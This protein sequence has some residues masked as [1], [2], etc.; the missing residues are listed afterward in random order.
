MLPM[1]LTCLQTEPNPPKGPEPVT[2]IWERMTSCRCAFKQVRPSTQGASCPTSSSVQLSSW[3][4][5][6]K[7]LLLGRLAGLHI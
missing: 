5:P 6:K 7:L 1:N 4:L 3:A 2:C